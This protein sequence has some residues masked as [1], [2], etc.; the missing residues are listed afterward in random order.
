M[1]GLETSV[2]L[3]MIGGAA[4]HGGRPFFPQDIAA[5]LA[6][7]PA[8]RVLVTTPV[9]LRACVKAGV[10]LPE[11]AFIISA[12][13]PLSLDLAHEA[14]AL[15]GTEVREIYGCT[16]AGSLASR[17]TVDGEAWQLYD[18]MQITLA[19]GCALLSGPQFTGTVALQDVIE[20][21]G[22][23][24]FA[25][26]GRDTDMVN[27]AGKR[28]SL[29]DLNHKLMQIPGVV[30]GV[31]FH[32]DADAATV[33]RL[34]ALVV[35]PSLKREQILAALGRCM[36]PVFLPRPLYLVEALPRNETSKLPRQALLAMLRQEAGRA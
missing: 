36:D 11:L 26:R 24:R 1:Y 7:V 35:A 22:D 16:E 21:L 5:A 14:E 9:H 2:L 13:A 3:A 30:D 34:A 25:L 29:A 12:T 32:S 4:V 18:G 28:A 8:P 19:D 17:R 10:R 27:I 20:P 31:I 6:S 33:E 15:F 23:D